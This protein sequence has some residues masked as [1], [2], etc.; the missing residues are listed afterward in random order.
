MR[1][2]KAIMFTDI[3]GFTGLMQND[4]AA[5]VRL[6]EQHKKIFLQCIEHCKGRVIKYI[7]DGTLTIF[8]SVLQ[9]IECAVAL[10]QAFQ[11]NPVIP[12]RIGIHIGEVIFENKDIIGDAVNLTSRIQTSG[13][14]G[15]VL[16]SEKVHEELSNHPEIVTVS[17]GFFYLKNVLQPVHL[18]AIAAEGLAIPNAIN[19]S[20]KSAVRPEIESPQKKWFGF[21]NVFGNVRLLINACIIIFILS[22]IF[23]LGSNFFK[24]RNM[25]NSKTI[26]V[27]PFKNI[28]RAGDNYLA[29]GLTEEMI[30]L[31]SENP[32]LTVIKIPFN[33]TKNYTED[34]FEE[35]LL[36]KNVGSVLEGSVQIDKGILVIF[37]RLRNIKTS[38]ILWANTYNENPAVL[39]KVQRLV[40]IQIN[41]ELNTSFGREKMKQFARK[42]PDPEAHDLYLKGRYAQKKRDTVSM[43]EALYYFKKA[44]IKDSTYALAYSGISDNYVIKI[45]NGDLPYDSGI[46]I[47]RNVL[48][49][50]LSLDSNIAEVRAS[51]AIYLSSLEGRRYQ[52]MHELK[53]ALNLNP[54]YVGAHQWYAVELVADGQFDSAIFHINK[55]L[56][57]EPFSERIWDQKIMILTYSRQYREA[58]RLYDSLIQNF[59]EKIQSLDLI[60]DCYF[61]LGNKDSVLICARTLGGNFYEFWKA[62]IKG[63]NNKIQI[64]IAQNISGVKVDYE[65]IANYYVSLGQNEN[66]LKTLE[67]AFADKEYSWLKFLNVAPYWDPLRKEPA[68][69]NLL[70]KMGFK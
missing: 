47:V 9:G 42:S 12:V 21:S 19:I 69:H 37:A 10:Q 63:D 5:A 24:S 46:N 54:N 17:L 60:A 23:L 14:A 50:A 6:L 4:E 8:A 40:A 32:D 55:A 30:G 59:P 68:F 45:D 70:F 22:L 3:E 33:V 62:V 1:I 16:V 15:S 61:G 31:L 48:S 18:Y 43:K 20:A 13:I 39:M 2:L 58:I 36:G 64:L 11:K 57:L 53:T 28:G 34:A 49:K 67:N 35:I 52:A 25:D 7:G 41:Q 56:E 27:L 51:N 26:A 44:L 38:E 66:A 65:L 29:E